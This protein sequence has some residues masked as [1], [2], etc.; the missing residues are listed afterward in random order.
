MDPAWQTWKQ[1]PAG[2]P[3]RL[4]ATLA[5]R[6][7]LVYLYGGLSGD[8]QPCGDLWRFSQ[9]DDCWAQIDVEQMSGR[10]DPSTYFDP[11]DGELSEPLT[12]GTVLDVARS[13]VVIPRGHSALPYAVPLPRTRHAMV[14][15]QEGPE[16][17][18]M[19]GGVDP[20]TGTVLGDLWEARV[21]ESLLGRHVRWHQLA[22]GDPDLA[23]GQRLEY[24]TKGDKIQRQRI[25]AA[26]RLTFAQQVSQLTV[27][28]NRPAP[29]PPPRAAHVMAA[30]G[31]FIFLHG[32]EGADFKPLGDLHMYDIGN[33]AW[34]PIRTPVPAPNPRSL[35]VGAACGTSFILAG[36]YHPTLPVD[37]VWIFEPGPVRWRQVDTRGPSPL[38]QGTPGQPWLAHGAVCDGQV[39]LML[40]GQRA[41]HTEAALWCL[42]L[43]SNQ[44]TRCEGVPPTA[45][46]AQCACGGHFTRDAHLR[47]SYQMATYGGTRGTELQARGWVGTITPP[48]PAPAAPIPAAL[49]TAAG[50]AAGRARKRRDQY[51]LEEQRTRLKFLTAADHPLI[52]HL[53]VSPVLTPYPV[54]QGLEA[55][56]LLHED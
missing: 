54:S 44:W 29:P 15:M 21:G 19:F 42:D 26:K 27:R 32:G 14:S 52:E 34:M 31:E 45:T 18:F 56:F 22:E 30:N 1:Q 48:A 23:T 33:R 7:G 9:Q 3:V 53:R 11:F 17:L 13:Q 12:A 38:S 47:T 50:G 49:V 43:R 51:T 2:P 35:H 20:G 37:D 36:G 6:P 4:S 46:A 28:A 5:S 10:S 55:H 41:L 39:L 8:G 40:G 16:R 25:A 24:L